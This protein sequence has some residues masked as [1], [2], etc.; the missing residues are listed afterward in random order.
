MG[1]LETPSLNCFVYSYD[2]LWVA[3]SGRGLPSSGERSERS[4]SSKNGTSVKR[5]TL[6]WT[7]RSG[8][9][10]RSVRE[11]KNFNRLLFPLG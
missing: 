7:L 6:S 2:G 10:V 9:S 1:V 11:R 5:G 8:G 4:V 3:G